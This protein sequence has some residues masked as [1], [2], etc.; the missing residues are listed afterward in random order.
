MC[1]KLFVICPQELLRKHV[2]HDIDLNIA[3]RSN[4]VHM[5]L[6]KA[7][8]LF[9]KNKLLQICEIGREKVCTDE[10]GVWQ[11]DSRYIFCR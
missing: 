3:K 7:L 6:Q 10:Y 4:H 2:S 8:Q 9:D 5:W 1:D 11:E